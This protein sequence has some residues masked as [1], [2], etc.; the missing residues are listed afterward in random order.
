MAVDGENIEIDAAE[1]TDSLSAEGISFSVDYAD[2]DESAVEVSNGVYE[3]P[4][5]HENVEAIVQATGFGARVITVIQS[6]ESPQR[7][8]YTFDVPKGTRFVPNIAG[9]SLEHGTDLMGTVREPWAFDSRG[10]EV[11]TYFTWFDGVLTQHVDLS[12]PGI[13]FPVVADPAWT[14]G[15]KYPVTKTA[16]ANKALLKKCFN[17][18]FP[19]AGAPKAFPRKGQ[20]LPLK[21]A[22]LHFECKF[23]SEFSG[24]S[25]F[26]FQFDATKNHVDKLGSNIIFQFRTIGGKRYLQINAYIVNDAFW[27]KNAI[28]RSGAQSTWKKFAA[29]LNKA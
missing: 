10:R 21:V 1:T 2:E 29:N 6:R 3:L 25:Y 5:E 4:G 23:K 19:V 7:Y 16:S 27:I 11:S 13:V 17:C 15:Y 28:Y 9:Y 8:D 12:D 24:S 26:G 14:Y 18:Y 22:G 20:L